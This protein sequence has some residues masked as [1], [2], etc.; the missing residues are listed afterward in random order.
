[1]DFNSELVPSVVAVVVVH[2]PGAEFDEVASALAA[3]DYGNLKTLFLIADGSADVEQAGAIPD[4]IRKKLPDAFIR[5]I[6]GNPGYGAAANEVL[7]LVEGD[8][9][10]FLLMHDDVA[11]E[12]GAVRLLVEELYRSNAGMVGPKLVLWDRPGTLQHVGLG[13][14]RFGEVDPL[15]EPGEADQEQHD[16][17]RDVFALPSACILVRA[18]LF[19]TLGG[20]DGTTNFYGEDVDLC[21]R[22]HL[23]GARVVVVPA[24][25]A[26]HRERLLVRRPDLAHHGLAARHRVRSVA[27]LTGGVR[28]PLVLLQMLLLCVLEIVVGLFTGRLGEAIASLRATLGLVPRVGSIIRRRREVSTL[29][30]VPYREVAGLQIRGSARLASYLRTREQLH[31]SVDHSAVGVRR[32][33]RN[34]VGQIAAWS[35]VMVLAVIGSRTF[36]LDGVPR[37]GEF[38]RFPTSARTLLGNYWSGWWGHGLGRTVAAPSGIGVLGVVGIASLGHMALFHTLAVLAWVPIGYY[39]AWRLMSIF[40]SSRARIVG[41]VAFAA[42]PLPYNALAAGRWSVVVAYGALPW[43]VHLMRKIAGIEPALDARA[44]AD[45]AD[46]LVVVS[47][48]EHV[49]AGAQLVLLSA[50]VTA[51]TPAFAGIV[52][53]VG[54]GLA[55]ATLLA[56]STVRTA[57]TL[58]VTGLGAGLMALLLNLPWMASL[59]GKNGW[60]TFVGAPTA[61]AGDVGLSHTLR[62]AVG[63]DKLGVLAIALWL[64]VIAAPLLARGWRLTWSARAGV[65]AVAA[66]A[67]AVAG[68]RNSLPFRLPEAGLLLAPA[69]VGLAI[70]AAC[71]AAAFEQDVQGGSFG[72]KQPL[73]ILCGAAVALGAIPSIASTANGRWSTPT[74]E[75]LQ[76]SDQFSANPPEGNSRSLYIGDARVMPIEGWRLDDS[77]TTGV[78]YS[79]ID[80]TAPDISEHWAGLPSKSESDVRDVLALMSNNSTAR[81]GRLLAPF[82]IRFIIVPLVDGIESTTV[83]TL[84]T[85]RGLIDSLTA[86]LDLRRV[87]TPPNYIAFENTAW[88]PTRAALGPAA[89]QASNEAGS[90]ALA[91]TDI[92]GSTPILI[93]MRDRG[94]ATGPV[95]AGVVYS[96]VPFDQRWTLAIG[97]AVIRPRTAFG[98][99]LAFDVPVA[100]TATLSYDTDVGRHLA[101]ALQLAAWIALLI[102]ASR[103]RWNWFRRRRPLLGADDGPVLRLGDLDQ[104]ALGMFDPFAPLAAVEPSLSVTE[105]DS[106]LPEPEMREPGLPE[107]GLPEP[108]LPEPGM[109]ERGP[110]DVIDES[111]TTGTSGEQTEEPR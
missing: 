24:A 68:Q 111:L 56:R 85:P 87:L 75:L 9:G 12:P 73:G 74:T 57:L 33:T 83:N 16:A 99:T 44:D 97:G 28:L 13:V 42:V 90:S 58:L 61:S 34:T 103:L 106:S 18:D 105:L 17:V 63:P 50:L 49:R 46:A 65:L 77:G 27:T 8:N 60:D 31:M 91:S 35:V 82:S 30:E 4:A 96:A 108:G 55:L 72:W 1:M 48:R 59:F 84:A 51:F 110:A 26:R 64:P 2:R 22:A 10:F 41:L 100:G 36:V 80:D 29:R 20:F 109:R 7:R 93:G 14:D 76:P 94:P 47:A 69:A 32:F 67:L 15:V 89:A 54:L 102:A 37:V 107:P 11:L 71:A 38:I 21:W 88:I 40:P 45:V 3:Q 62:F 79:I 70:A 101:V 6:A 43:I 52:A 95:P 104:P 23:S 66:L 53:V 39:G 86:Q 5:A 98:D 25:K 19:R 81:I 92:S 78:S